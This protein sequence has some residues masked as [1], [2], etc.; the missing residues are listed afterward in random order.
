MNETLSALSA[1]LP[2][3]AGAQPVLSPLIHQHFKY[4]RKVEMVKAG[5][6]TG[7]D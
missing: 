1:R 2:H 3:A 6:K 7:K 4:K 5:A